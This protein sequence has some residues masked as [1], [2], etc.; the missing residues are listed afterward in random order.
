MCSKLLIKNKVTGMVWNVSED[1]YKY[2]ISQDNYVKYTEKKDKKKEKGVD[3][4]SS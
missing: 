2:L 4:E 1:H 3:D